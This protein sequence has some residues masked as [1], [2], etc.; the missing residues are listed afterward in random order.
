MPFFG[1][2]D[3]QGGQS[4]PA[5]ITWNLLTITYGAVAHAAH[6]FLFASKFASS[7]YEVQLN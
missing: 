1:K 3:E 7:P 4:K 2:L 6:F 5:T